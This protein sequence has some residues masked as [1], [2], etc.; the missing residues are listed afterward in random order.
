MPFLDDLGLNKYDRKI[1]QYIK[2]K[3][4]S[5][6]VSS[7]RLDKL[8]YTV[9]MLKTQSALI[10]VNVTTSD[11]RPFPGLKV[12]NLRS[13]DGSAVT[14][15]DSGKAIGLATATNNFKPA[16][17]SYAD[18]SA[19]NC[20]ATNI[21]SG[22]EY[23]VPVTAVLQNFIQYTSSQS[24]MFSSFI[25]SIDCSLVGGGGGGGSN[26]GGGGGG[27]GVSNVYQVSVIPNT[28]YKI[29]IASG[30]AGAYHDGTSW[31]SATKGGSTT[32]M[33]LTAGGGNPGGSN[34]GG[35][36]TGG[37]GGGKG[38]SYANDESE[39]S[40]SLA[41]GSNGT[42]SRFSSY[43][44]VTAYGPGGGGGYSYSTATWASGGNSG[45]GRGGYRNT[46]GNYWNG[47][48]GSGGGG[49]GGGGDY[50][51]SSYGTG[52]SGGPGLMM[53]RMHH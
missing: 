43:T 41:R 27:G 18:I 46:T 44:E 26:R 31:Q 8:E 52:G 13:L 45:G 12:T 42:I 48:T 32:F 5:S 37:T 34:R 36:G 11:G 2:E 53:I 4:Q 7:D 1:K 17:Q 15:D 20:S 39:S 47:G 6:G 19:Y 50:T 51:G 28:S 33:N 10:T 30:G 29:E 9:E 25:S 40:Q 24:I 16:F 23:T 3:N 22:N 14:T 38:G 35:G 21:V 49:G